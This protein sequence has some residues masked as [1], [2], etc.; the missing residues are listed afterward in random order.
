MRRGHHL[1]TGCSVR[2]RADDVNLLATTCLTFSSIPISLSNWVAIAGVS[3]PRLRSG[4]L[5]SSA[6]FQRVNAS[7]SEI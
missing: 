2:T 5:V 1:A 3:Q 7:I 4:Q 6:S